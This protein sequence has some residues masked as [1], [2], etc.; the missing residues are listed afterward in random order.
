V[1][2]NEEK[3]IIDADTGWCSSYTTRGTYLLFVKKKKKSEERVDGK[4][5]R[6]VAVSTKPENQMSTARSQE[7]KKLPRMRRQKWPRKTEKDFA[8]KKRKAKGDEK[9]GTTQ[10]ERDTSDGSF[11]TR[12]FGC[13]AA[14]V[15]A[16]IDF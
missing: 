8:Q 1:K 3:E 5:K 14:K 7:A 2:K 11:G 6:L 4:K 9:R 10:K 15:R 13:E 12:G 16:G